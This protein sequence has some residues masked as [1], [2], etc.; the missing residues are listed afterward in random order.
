MITTSIDQHSVVAPPAPTS[1]AVADARALLHETADALGLD[2]GTREML[3]LPER[4]VSVSIPVVMD[5]GDVAVFPGYRVDEG[6]VWGLTRRV[7]QDF[8]G[9]LA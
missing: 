3:A 8:L 1:R 2:P 9:R 4:A 6:V 5:D 7:L